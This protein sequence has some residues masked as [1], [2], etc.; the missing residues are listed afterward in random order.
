MNN[1]NINDSF[2]KLLDSTFIIYKGLRFEKTSAGYLH[3]GAL[4]RDHFEMDI[5]VEQER[6]ALENSI[7]PKPC[8]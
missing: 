1:Y 3:N 4:C 5:L 2:Q 8:P 6:H 7:K